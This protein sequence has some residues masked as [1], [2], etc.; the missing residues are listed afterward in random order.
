MINRRLLCSILEEPGSM[1]GTK[2]VERRLAVRRACR[3]LHLVLF[4]RECSRRRCRVSRGFI[5]SSSDGRLVVLD[6]GM[7]KPTRYSNQAESAMKHLAVL[8]TGHHGH[9]DK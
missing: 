7:H 3:G 4:S 8:E 1:Q 2:Q 5:N 6:T 9:A